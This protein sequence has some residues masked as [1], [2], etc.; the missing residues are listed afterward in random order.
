[1]KRNVCA[2][3]AAAILL[4]G[5]AEVGEARHGGHYRG[6]GH[7]H[8]HFWI[9]A[10]FWLATPWAYPVWHA[11][12][13]YQAPPVVIERQAP[14]YIQPEPLYWYHCQDPQGYYPYIRQCPGGWQK[15]VPSAPPAP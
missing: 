15:V 2:L 5:L 6:H 8:G 13:Y 7:Y 3:M 10:P 1:M 9:G 14:T 4:V 11:P 12:R